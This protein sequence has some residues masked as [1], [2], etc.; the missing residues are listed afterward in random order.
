MFSVPTNKA[1]NAN[2]EKRWKT[3]QERESCRIFSV[4]HIHWNLHWHSMEFS[5]LVCTFRL[6]FCLDGRL[7]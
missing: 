5:I 2:I 6:Y 1:I 4:V 3:S 7:F